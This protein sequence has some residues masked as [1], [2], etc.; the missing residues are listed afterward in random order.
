MSSSLFPA[1]QNSPVLK[2]GLLKTGTRESVFI[3]SGNL[4]WYG[5]AWSNYG[6]LWYYQGNSQ[7]WTTFN[8]SN[9]AGNL[10]STLS[11]GESITQVVLITQGTTGYL[12]TQFYVDN[13]ATTV[14]WAGGSAPT[15]STNAI[16]ALSFTLIKT[17]TSSHILLG[18][19]TKYA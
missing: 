8:V 15:A 14:K 17:G 18:S 10:L 9:Q 13:T 11:V 7:S 4:S 19:F 2:N 5:A 3:V 6:A 12:P 16:D 1:V